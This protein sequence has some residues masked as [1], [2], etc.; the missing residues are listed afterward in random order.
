MLKVM[1]DTDICLDLLSG[2]QPFN[3][4]AEQL[5]RLAELS[6]I[7]ICVSSLSFANID[8]IIQSQYK[9]NDSR[10]ILANFKSL[11]ELLSIGDQIIQLANHSAFID[12]E[13]AIQYYSALENNIGI[14]ITR[15]LKDYKNPIID[16][17]NPETYL[18][19]IN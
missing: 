15:N 18:A 10:Y 19:G 13:D 12:F 4:S 14:L 7:T 2:R 8:Y 6:Q 9:R 1:V 11:V 17:M 3:Q 16:I 5:F